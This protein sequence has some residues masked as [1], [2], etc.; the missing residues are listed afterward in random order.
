MKMST[1]RFLLCL[2]SLSLCSCS[3]PVESTG[4]STKQSQSLSTSTNIS[5]T[6]SS[7]LSNSSSKS[8]EPEEN[9]E[10]EDILALYQKDR[11]FIV[12]VDSP[13]FV[14]TISY[15]K[16]A[17][18]LYAADQS[19][20]T[21]YTNKGYGETKGGIFSFIKKKDG[22]IKATSKFLVGSNGRFLRGLYTSS[23]VPSL[24]TIDIDSLKIETLDESNVYKIDPSSFL[25]LYY[26]AGILS[27][28]G[29]E[30]KLLLNTSYLTCT[31]KDGY[32]L[33]FETEVY[34]TKFT[35]TFSSLGRECNAEFDQY[36]EN[37]G[38]DDDTESKMKDLLKNYSYRCYQYKDLEDGS[39]ELYATEYYTKDYMYIEY[40]NPDAEHASVGYVGLSSKSGYTSG[41]HAFYLN[42][43]GIEIESEVISSSTNSL[44]EYTTYP[45]DYMAFEAFST[46]SYNE[47]N[48]MYVLYA[49]ENQNVSLETCSVLGL[50][51]YVN[52]LYPY[53][54]GIRFKENVKNENKS[55]IEVIYIYQNFADNGNIGTYSK[56]Y[57]DFNNGNSKAVDK[58]LT[59]Y[60]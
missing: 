38:K 10:L 17:V 32:L 12:D 56:T 13:S 39:I 3:T 19:G 1:N 50:E 26:M 24:E 11:R 6:T 14:E 20:E 34:K 57:T 44:I 16:N 25:M 4:T 51:D 30:E 52:T 7:S 45:T 47:V 59:P 42:P 54:T 49:S 36:I 8:E 18:Y 46:F 9:L 37:G 23:L 22:S 60:L 33:E 2:L 31:V 21:V 28:S 5:K 48:D 55:S 41:I 35:I 58:V 43:N 15:S 40:A 27:S 53:G 29:E